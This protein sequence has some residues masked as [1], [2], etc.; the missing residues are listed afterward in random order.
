MR[1]NFVAINSIDETADRTRI[2]VHLEKS[3]EVPPFSEVEAI[4]SIGEVN[5]GEW[6]L[7]GEAL[8]VANGC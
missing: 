8:P 6:L 4:A 5:E 2:N 3:I 7:E 1:S